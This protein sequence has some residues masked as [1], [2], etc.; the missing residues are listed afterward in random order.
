MT[1]TA[2]HLDAKGKLALSRAELLGVMGY[3]EVQHNGDGRSVI[4]LLP[5]P[6]S[7]SWTDKLGASVIGHWWKGHPLN[8]VAQLAKPALQQYANHHPGKLILY[9]AGV[10]CLLTVLKAW[11]LVSVGAVFALLFKG[12]DTA[13]LLATALPQSN[14]AQAD[15]RLTGE[16][17][18]R[19][20]LLQD[21][22][23]ARTA[24]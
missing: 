7:I 14:S 17:S 12:R 19:E 1:E 5:K 20:D 23:G 16:D 24:R 3:R 6:E 15:P 21:R 13:A 22:S 2:D 9:G 10:G 11:K 18:L 4:Q 8:M